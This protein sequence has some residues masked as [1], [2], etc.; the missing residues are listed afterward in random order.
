MTNRTVSFYININELS[1]IDFAPTEEE[2]RGMLSYL[3][4]PL[5]EKHWSDEDPY[6]GE[7]IHYTVM[8]NQVIHFAWTYRGAGLPDSF[9][10]EY[11][12]RTLHEQWE[13]DHP[14]WDFNF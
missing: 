6:T 10:C 7:P 14:N 11:Q 3:Q 12:R 9:R 13:L 8:E 4:L 2:V 1:N 5:I